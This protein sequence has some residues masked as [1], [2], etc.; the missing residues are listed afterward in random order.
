MELFEAL[1]AVQGAGA[2]GYIHRTLRNSAVSTQH[3][4]TANTGTRLVAAV[5][6][7]MKSGRP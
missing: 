6:L 1:S 7:K 3:L 5:R 4:P 2:R